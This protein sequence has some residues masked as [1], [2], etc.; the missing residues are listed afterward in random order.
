MQSNEESVES[1]VK[2]YLEDVCGSEAICHRG[3]LFK[4]DLSVREMVF[5]DPRTLK[6]FSSSGKFYL[7]K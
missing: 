4:S 2:K 6:L 3:K 1:L 5:Q 7:T